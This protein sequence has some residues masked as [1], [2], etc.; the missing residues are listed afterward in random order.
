VD[1][2]Y[3][4]FEIKSVDDDQRLI[5]GIASSPATDRKGDILDPKGAIFSLPIPLLWQHRADQPIGH[6]TAAKVTKDGIAITAKIAKGIAEIDRAWSLIKEG[7]VRGLSVG[8]RPTKDP[9]LIKGTWGLHFTDWEWL[10]LSAVTIPA[11]A[12]ATITTIK[13]YDRDAPAATGGSAPRVITPPT[14]V[15]RSK[16]D[17]TM[18][19]TSEMLTAV[20][21]DLTAKTAR[22]EELTA[23]ENTDGSLDDAQTTERDGLLTSVKSLTNRVSSLQTI[24][25]ARALQTKGVTL[26]SRANPDGLPAH[27][28]GN[29]KPVELPPGIEFSRYVICRMAGILTGMSPLDIA[30]RRYPDQPRIQMLIK[31]AVGAGST[32]DGGASGPGFAEPLVYATNL[33]SEFVDFLRPMTIVGKLQGMT[34]VPF[35][36]RITGQSTGGTGYWVGEGRAKPL[37]MFNVTASTL[38]WAK[39]A[40]ISVITDELARFSSPSAEML[41]RNEL[42]KALTAR[43]DLD[44]IDPSKAAVANVSPAS[45]TNGLTPLSSSGTDLATVDLDVAKFFNQFIT[46]NVNPTTAA[47]IMPNTLALSLSLMRIAAS[48][49]KAFPDITMNGGTFQ[50]LPV[51][52]SQYAS[53]QYLGSPYNNIVILVN[54]EDIFLADDGGFTVDISREASLEM[55]D[56]PVM[57]AGVE[58]TPVSPTSAG[59][60]SMFQ[61]NSM[62]IRCERYINWARRR[63][64]GVG[65]ALMDDV[66]WGAIVDNP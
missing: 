35:N 41:V 34:R 50:G 45:I 63:A 18:P 62:A 51:I 21:N 37:T 40:A 61:T 54:A 5:E 57:R 44:F 29:P 58:G 22:L 46:T 10:E 49:V 48:G 28:V 6:V 1:R 2:A 24:E 27:Q 42:A 47:W 33:V 59:V 16:Q 60:V 65:V 25:A 26:P 31:E 56:A 38:T 12:D 43:M 39:V 66:N 32:M 52:T 55:D 15:S 19:P 11:N 30:R 17:T 36:V 7:L 64:S 3:S 9:E 13:S 4:T 53:G 23:L 20:S 8:F 14:V